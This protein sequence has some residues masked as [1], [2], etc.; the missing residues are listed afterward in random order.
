MRA[1]GLTPPL[2]LVL[3]AVAFVALGQGGV[4]SRTHLITG[5]LLAAAVAA[6]TGRGDLTLKHAQSSVILTAGAVACWAT[7]R[8]TIAGDVRLGLGTATLL[9]GVAAVYAV[10]NAAAP[11]VRDQLVSGLLAAGA[12]VAL[13]GWVGVVLRWE[14]L[15]LASAGVWRAATTITY[16]NASAA[17]LVCMALVATGR[18]LAQPSRTSSAATMLLMVGAAATMSRAA[19]VALATGLVVLAVGVGARR[20]ATALVAPVTGAVIA[21]VALLPSMPVEATA[22]P[23]LATAGLAIGTGATIMLAT[24]SPVRGRTLVAGVVLA[25]IV[26]VTVLAS[27]DLSDRLSLVPSDR[28]ERNQAALEMYIENPVIGSGP[29]PLWLTW[30]DARG[31]TVGAWH[32]HNEYLQVLVQLGAI[33]GLLVAALLVAVVGA[34]RRGRAAAPEPAAWWGIAAGLTALAVHSSFDFLWH[35]PAIPLLGAAL[36]AAAAQSTSKEEVVDG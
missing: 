30:E 26:G 23:A 24:R 21:L 15:A 36:V 7:A 5:G 4:F 14:P 17:V 25:A 6:A 10:T 12:L 20:M 32:V 33:G 35:V 8:A 28:V 31:R 27:I 9:A 13:S 16:T 11:R 29:G 34:V 3:T 18:L 2:V 22:R 19:L 1:S